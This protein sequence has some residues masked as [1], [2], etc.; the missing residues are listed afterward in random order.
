MAGG[1]LYGLREAQFVNFCSLYE[2]MIDKKFI[3]RL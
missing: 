2:F 3:M 1:F